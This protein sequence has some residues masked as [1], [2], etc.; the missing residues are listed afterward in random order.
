MGNYSSADISRFIHK[1]SGQIGIPIDEDA[2]QFIADASQGQ[3]SRAKK[4]TMRLRDFAE[5]EG[6]ASIGLEYAR[7]KLSTLITQDIL[8]CGYI[9][10]CPMTDDFI[11]P[12]VNSLH[13]N[14][15]GLSQRFRRSTEVY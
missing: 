11:C 1:L 3:M 15:S 7:E 10:E 2:G 5:V 13:Q 14:T 6:V 12:R 4:L 9:H 8:I